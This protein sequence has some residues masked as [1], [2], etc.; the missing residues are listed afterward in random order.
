MAFFPPAKTFDWFIATHSI[1]PSSIM[2]KK[3][4]TLALA[5]LLVLTGK[6]QTTPSARMVTPVNVEIKQN[7]NQFQLLRAGQPY[8]GVSCITGT[9][10][11]SAY[12]K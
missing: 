3:I 10:V 8:F 11:S 5:L 4:I 2:V 9:K 12:S 1:K 6:A 7:G